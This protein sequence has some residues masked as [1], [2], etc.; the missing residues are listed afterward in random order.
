MATFCANQPPAAA[1]A[2]PL[3]TVE[4]PP[5]PF[6][7]GPLKPT[8]T[9]GTAVVGAAVEGLRAG[10]AAWAGC[11]FRAAHTA[12]AT[13]CGKDRAP[14][15][16]RCV[17]ALPPAPEPAGLQLPPLLSAVCGGCRCSSHHRQR[18]D[19]SRRVGG[20]DTIWPGV[21]RT[22]PAVHVFGAGRVRCCRQIVPRGVGISGFECLWSGCRGWPDQQPQQDRRRRSHVRRCA[23]RTVGT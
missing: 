2:P 14:D 17:T 16:R 9:P 11:R 1:P 12:S 23:V 3:S 20:G 5:P 15:G 4:P 7:P 22:M 6:P 10:R 13:R 8:A 21:R 18:D 19:T